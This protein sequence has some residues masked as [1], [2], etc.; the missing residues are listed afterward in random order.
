MKLNF[1]AVLCVIL[2]NTLC[3]LSSPVN[4]LDKRNI[5]LS[6][7]CWAQGGAKYRNKWVCCSFDCQREPHSACAADCHAGRTCEGNKGMVPNGTA[8]CSKGC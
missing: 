6:P 2:I 5:F 3:I 4:K 7:I 8:C 1:F